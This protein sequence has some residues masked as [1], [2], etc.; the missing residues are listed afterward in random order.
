M[1]E[2]GTLDS[3]ETQSAAVCDAVGRPLNL[4]THYTDVRLA[5]RERCGKRFQRHTIQRSIGFGM[6]E[7]KD[8]H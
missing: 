7:D 6:K 5:Q 4:F 1:S 2:L 8:I 3:K